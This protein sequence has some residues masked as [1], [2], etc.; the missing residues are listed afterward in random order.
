MAEAVEGA[1]ADAGHVSA[2]FLND[3][4][5]PG[6]HTSV[7]PEPTS[8]EQQ[9]CRI[10]P[11]QATTLL[12]DILANVSHEYVSHIQGCGSYNDHKSLET[13]YEHAV[14]RSGRSLTHPPSVCDGADRGQFQDEAQPLLDTQAE[15]DRLL[16]LIPGNTF[17]PGLGHLSNVEVRSTFVT[18]DSEIQTLQQATAKFLD[19]RR[20]G[21]FIFFDDKVDFELLGD[22]FLLAENTSDIG[23]SV[24]HPTAESMLSLIDELVNS[25]NLVEYVADTMPYIDQQPQYNAYARKPC[26]ADW[27]RRSAIFDPTGNQH[28]SYT[29]L[30]Q[31]ITHSSCTPQ[32]TCAQSYAAENISDVFD[33]EVDKSS[34]NQPS[35]LDVGTSDKLTMGEP[36]E[37]TY[38]DTYIQQP[39]AYTAFNQLLVNL[40]NDETLQ[41]VHRSGDVFD[42]DDSSLAAGVLEIGD[43]SVDDGTTE[44]ASS[45][46]DTND[47][48]GFDFEFGRNLGSWPGQPANTGGRRSIN[49]LRSYT[50]LQRLKSRRCTFLAIDTQLA[51]IV[52]VSSDEDEAPSS[53]SSDSSIEFTGQR[54]FVQEL[55]VR[56]TDFL[57]DEDSDDDV[58]GAQ[59]APSP[60]SS[61]APVSTS[62]HTS[63]VDE[64]TF[65]LY[66]DCIW[67][68][69]PSLPLYLRR[70]PT[71]PQPPSPSAFGSLNNDRLDAI[72]TEILKLIAISFEC[73]SQGQL[74]SLR[75]LGS[76]LQWASNAITEVFPGLGLITHLSTVVEILL[77]RIVTLSS[78]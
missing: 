56:R 47:F 65:E 18:Y 57:A 41:H 50:F 25:D 1:D 45:L 43:F 6:V 10:Y 32:P 39:V 67:H 73:I 24:Q 72:E 60:V 77:E 49:S 8:S 16:S 53:S 31:L 34:M 28:I 20:S 48:S 75:S 61:D 52:E 5:P 46:P 70:S 38:F 55:S 37:L 3:S 68:A 51:N 13:A 78:N 58:E 71:Q 62:A 33:E 54:G 40:D 66:S 12:F 27:P 64:S 69:E 17:L 21:E 26:G 44:L 14:P 2:V 35:T 74:A 9:V 36:C 22:N 59:S 4:A 23:L 7:M 42:E 19:D 30:D 11:A 76:D 29:A 15:V 63:H